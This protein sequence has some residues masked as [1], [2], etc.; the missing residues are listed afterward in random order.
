[1]YCT[2]RGRRRAHERARLLALRPA[3]NPR[4]SIDFDGSLDL[5]ENSPG[6]L[7]KWVGA[8]ATDDTA[9]DAL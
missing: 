8:G 5:R 4:G 9:F 3:A 7:R 2:S 6:I 1:M